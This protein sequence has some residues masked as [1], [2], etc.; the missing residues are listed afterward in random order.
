MLR[1]ETQNKR[2]SDAGLSGRGNRWAFLCLD[3]SRVVYT[4]GKAIW[5]ADR[6][7]W[8]GWGQLIG[9]MSPAMNDRCD[10]YKGRNGESFSH[11]PF[12]SCLLLLLLGP[13]GLR[14]SRGDFRPLQT[15]RVHNPY[16]VKVTHSE[17]SRWNPLNIL[18]VC[19]SCQF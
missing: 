8:K 3:G 7:R 9:S 18:E 6:S 13:A 17:R 5:I 16:L 4:Q 15:K 14:S 10:G 12:I 2:V 19:L 11:N 1:A